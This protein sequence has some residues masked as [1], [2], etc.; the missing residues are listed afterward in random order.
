[1]NWYAFF[2]I[3]LVAAGFVTYGPFSFDYG[4]VLVIAGVLSLF[5]A[6]LK[7]KTWI[8]GLGIVTIITPFVIPVAEQWVYYALGV[9]IAF[10]IAGILM[11]KGE[12]L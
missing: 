9:G 3:V 8:F 4:Y 11:K 10:I 1:M 2:G 12:S 5:L 6:K 7:M